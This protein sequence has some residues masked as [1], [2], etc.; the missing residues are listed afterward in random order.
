MKPATV[1]GLGVDIIRILR[2]SRLLQKDKVFVDRLCSRIL[3]NSEYE[4]FHKLE[5][6][7]ASRYLA[8]S[9]AAKEAL[10]KTLDEHDQKNFQF[11]QWFRHYQGKKPFILKDG[12][13]S[14]EQFHLSISHDGDVLV[15]TVLRQRDNEKV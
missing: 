7:S 5:S 14:D 13:R 12:Y 8:G 15:A 2:F 3:H 10:F 9:W 6:L 1:V 11:C 4:G